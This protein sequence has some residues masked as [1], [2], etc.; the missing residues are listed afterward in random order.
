M[1]EISTNGIRAHAPWYLSAA[2]KFLAAGL[3]ARQ[4]NMEGVLS[5]ISSGKDICDREKILK[6]LG[7]RAYLQSVTRLNGYVFA[8][9]APNVA[10]SVVAKAK[11]GEEKE[12]KAVE[13]AVVWH[14]SGPN[15]L[16]EKI[17]D[18][19]DAPMLNAWAE[20]ILKVLRNEWLVNQIRSAH[21]LPPVVAKRITMAT[22]EG[23]DHGWQGALISLQEGDIK[24]VVMDGLEK[25][26]LDPYAN[27]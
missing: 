23:T 4:S 26:E 25:K 22:L 16:W 21:G 7:D 11:K 10:V 17:V 3:L 14:Q 1:L 20:Y 13:E 9:I 6:N 15:L 2:G 19:T 27:H 12:A 5:S 8:I 24:A 18:M